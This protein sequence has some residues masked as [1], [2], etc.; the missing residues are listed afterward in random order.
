MRPNLFVEVE[1][2]C[3]R[4]GNKAG[5][6][7]ESEVL[8]CP[9]NEHHYLVLKLDDVSQVNERPHDPGQQSGKLDAKYIRNRI[10]AS[11]HREGSLIEILKWWRRKPVLVLR[12]NRSGRVSTL[13]HS[14]LSHA[15]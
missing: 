9:L 10:C 11:N 4:T 7:A 6:T 3:R 5:S 12:H 8:E 2:C 1:V 13:L 15:S 14:N